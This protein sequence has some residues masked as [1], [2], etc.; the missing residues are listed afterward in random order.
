[1][2][3]MFQGWCSRSVRGTIVIPRA[4][5]TVE[6]TVTHI[7]MVPRQ[8][9]DRARAVENAKSAFPTSSLHAHRTRAHTLHRH[10]H[11]GNEQNKTRTMTDPLQCEEDLE[12]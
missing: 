12:T 4:P 6:L 7:G 8:P 3:A 11:Q 10:T 2:I 9:V 5:Y 1:M